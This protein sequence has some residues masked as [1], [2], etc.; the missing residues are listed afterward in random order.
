MPVRHTPV[1][2]YFLQALDWPEPLTYA[3]GAGVGFWAFRLSRK[4]GYLLVASY[5]CVVVFSLL[6][7]PRI[8]AELDARRAPTQSEETQRKISAAVSEAVDGV[9]N[10]EGVQPGAGERNIHIPLGPLLLVIGVWLLTRGEARPGG[11]EVVS[12]TPK[13]EATTA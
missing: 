10:K 5:F 8:K 13:D 3:T 4:V 7:L 1:M 12:G 9:L 2:P 11:R 6:A